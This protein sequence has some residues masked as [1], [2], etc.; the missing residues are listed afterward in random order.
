[1]WRSGAGRVRLS[2][3]EKIIGVGGWRVENLFEAVDSGEVWVHPRIT[4]Y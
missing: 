2:K 1:M 4:Y 3:S